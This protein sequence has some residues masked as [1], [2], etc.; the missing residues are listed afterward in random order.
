MRIPITANKKTTN[1]HIAVMT[2]AV[3]ESY[4]GTTAFLKT[5]V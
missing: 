3:S 5:R 4:Q 2:Q 1:M